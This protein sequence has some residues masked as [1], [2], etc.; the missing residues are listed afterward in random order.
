MW[1][2]KDSDGNII[3]NRV[4]LDC[5]KA[6]EEGESVLV[7]QSHSQEVDINNIIK[8]HGGKVELIA[9]TANVQA[10]RFDDNPNNDFQEV[11]NM[12]IKGKQ[13]F[14]SLPSEVR[15]HFGNNV[16]EFMDYVRNPDNSDQLIAWGLQEPPEP[17][18]API[19]VAV[20]NQ[21]AETPSES[22]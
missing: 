19:A 2:R 13:S 6:I 22:V 18:A 7:E 4:T 17:P 21:T 5:Q 15:R 14:E 16:A 1:N 11:M 20:V 12:L 9:S 10:L 8:R 3:R